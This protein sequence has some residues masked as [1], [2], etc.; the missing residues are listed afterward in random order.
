MIALHLPPQAQ[1]ALSD[2][3][4]ETAEPAAT[5]PIAFTGHAQQLAP[6]TAEGQ[7][8][9][10]VVTCSMNRC[11]NLIKAMPSWLSHPQISEVVVVDWSSR[12][13]VRQDLAQA[14]ITDPRTASCGSRMRP[15]GSCP[16]PSTPGF[17]PLPATPS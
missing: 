12:Q 3:L 10:S 9:I 16:M 1:P 11:E 7:R 15:A 14:G 6:L 4:A 8:G 17:A 2:M 5:L 13:P